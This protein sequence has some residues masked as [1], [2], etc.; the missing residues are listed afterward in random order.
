ML[1]LTNHVFCSMIFSMSNP[2]YWKGFL[3]FF[4][5]LL[6]PVFWLFNEIL[7]QFSASRYR[8][9]LWWVRSKVSGVQGYIGCYAAINGLYPWAAFSCC[10]CSIPVISNYIQDAYDIR[11]LHFIWGVFSFLLCS[12]MYNNSCQLPHPM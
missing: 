2:T 3:W 10:K 5:S 1:I 6:W 12:S 11:L 8:D 9:N 4:V 7:E